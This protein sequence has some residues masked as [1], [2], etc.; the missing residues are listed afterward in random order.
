MQSKRR[1]SDFFISFFAVL[2]IIFFGWL[3]YKFILYFFNLLS[4]LDPNVLGTIIAGFITIFGSTLAVVL[5][6]YYQVKQNQEKALNEKKIE[7]YN[8]TIKK[9]Y[10]TIIGDKKESQEDLIKFINEAQQNLIIWANPKVLIAYSDWRKVL[11]KEPGKIKSLYKMID[12]F[13]AFR[14]DLGHNNKKITYEHF[15]RIMFKHPDL[16]LESYKNNNN[17]SFDEIAAKEKELF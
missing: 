8:A 5:T 4:L 2:I 17:I 6:R 15:F 1:F 3:L 9:I 14:E 13:L 16:I 12:L 7:L 11:Q 10:G